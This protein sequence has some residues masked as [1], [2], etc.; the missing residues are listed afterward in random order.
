MVGTLGIF[1]LTNNRTCPAEANSTEM[2]H[3]YGTWS[4]SVTTVTTYTC[5]LFLNPSYFWKPFSISSAQF[6]INQYTRQLILSVTMW[7]FM[8]FYFMIRRA[9]PFDKEIPACTERIQDQIYTKITISFV[10]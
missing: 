9:L 2:H 7:P 4:K 10:S 5:S 8:P 3:L 1:F 6:P